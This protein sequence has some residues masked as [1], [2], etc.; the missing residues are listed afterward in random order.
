MSSL[1]AVGWRRLGCHRTAITPTSAV[2]NSPSACRAR[3]N[4]PLSRRHR[5]QL[6]RA[7]SSPPRALPSDTSDKQW[8][9][10]NP[11]A[12]GD[13][14][15]SYSFDD[16]N[17]DGEADE[18]SVAP[19]R[20]VNNTTRSSNMQPSSSS[21]SSSGTVQ[22]SSGVSASSGPA[23]T[24]DSP[25]P[26]DDEMGG[27]MDDPAGADFDGFGD[28]DG[29]GFGDGA[30]GLPPSSGMPRPPADMAAMKKMMMEAG[31]GDM[32]NDPRFEKMFSEG[33]DPANPDF[34]PYDNLPMDD[35]DPYG[36]DGGDSMPGGGAGSTGP[37][38]GSMGGGGGKPSQ[39]PPPFPG[40][41]G[42]PPAPASKP[43]PAPP[44]SEPWGSSFMKPKKKKAAPAPAAAPAAVVS[45]RSDAPSES[46]D[47]VNHTVTPSS[48]SG[49]SPSAITP[50]TTPPTAALPGA[51]EA[52]TASSSSSSSEASHSASAPKPT[53]TPTPTAKPR[54]LTLSGPRRT[55]AP[56]PR[57]RPPMSASDFDFSSPAAAAAAAA[58]LEPQAPSTR[59]PSTLEDAAPAAP[60]AKR[61]PRPR[62]AAAAAA[63][64]KDTSGGD[65]P[66]R[67]R[68][69]FRSS[70]LDSGAAGSDT[71][72]TQS[73]ASGS[74]PTKEWGASPAAAAAAAAAAAPSTPAQYLKAPVVVRRAKPGT[75]SSS[76]SGAAAAESVPVPAAPETASSGVAELLTG[77]RL[78]LPRK[79]R[80]GAL[81]AQD[82]SAGGQ[83]QPQQQQQSVPGLELPTI[84]SSKKPASRAGARKPVGTDTA[85]LSPSSLTSDTPAPVLPPL[86]AAASAAADPDP[87]SAPRDGS[88]KAEAAGRRVRSA[89]EEQRAFTM[90][91]AADTPERD[92][93]GAV[94][95][96]LGKGRRV[97]I[98]VLGTQSTYR[99]AKILATAQRY[100]HERHSLHLALQP[101][102][103]M[104]HT[105]VKTSTYPSHPASP[106]HPSASSILTA[107]RHD[108]S[109]SHSGSRSQPGARNRPPARAAAAVV[110]GGQEGGVVTDRGPARHLPLRVYVSALPVAAQ[111]WG[112][113][114][115]EDEGWGQ[116]WVGG[117]THP[118][119]LAYALQRRVEVGGGGLS[120][121]D[122]GE[123]ALQALALARHHFWAVGS[124]LAA[125]P[126]WH[127]LPPRQDGEPNKVLR[128][129][130][131]LCSQWQPSAP[132]QGSDELIVPH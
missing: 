76:S 108:P 103:L 10:S 33:F 123:R 48:D 131:R 72:S 5:Q 130:V 28:F 49:N 71:G 126:S 93:A 40:G 21:S 112:G 80:E 67:A 42:G 110:V 85:S 29:G 118:S 2:P 61:Q 89:E 6:L 120:C 13:G 64:A 66:G 122:A 20:S 94:V 79:K 119:K 90:R 3:T 82:S 75:S 81:A 70:T 23:P 117:A 45:S 124:D 54:R 43:A 69:D 16:D 44:R 1:Q 113:R 60:A 125:T 74:L 58:R 132:M 100:A 86:A 106:S 59:P 77:K 52:A 129:N 4:Q 121:P 32:V 19:A 57:E 97:L 17:V 22:A 31:M 27:Y 84:Q 107:P 26:W 39:M 99:A 109:A 128:F 9:S 7:L 92:A 78:P 38:G 12:S 116:L 8:T 36:E 73:P 62:A 101:T 115:R 102:A 91:F 25:S 41:F 14:S 15:D 56:P 98:E 104:Q 11:A 37:W 88:V 68:Y 46:P 83:Q 65:A 127:D 105:L 96:Q 35:W 55:A 24:D 111:P 63:V 47:A 53:P 34:D 50:P 95:A 51:Q 87:S 30:G 114:A 18:S